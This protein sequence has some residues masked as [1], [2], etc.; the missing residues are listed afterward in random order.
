M[1]SSLIVCSPPRQTGAGAGRSSD[2]RC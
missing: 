1:F 2:S